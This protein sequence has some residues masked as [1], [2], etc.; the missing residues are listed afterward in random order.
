MTTALNDQYPDAIVPALTGENK[1]R[2]TYQL[3]IETV[4]VKDEF[5]LLYQRDFPLA[6]RLWM[7]ERMNARLLGTSSTLTGNPGRL[8]HVWYVEWGFSL[9][10]MH[11][12]LYEE[13]Q[14][15]D[16]PKEMFGRLNN[17]SYDVLVPTPYDPGRC[18]RVPGSTQRCSCQDAPISAPS[19]SC[20]ESISSPIQTNGPQRCVARL[21]DVIDVKPGRLSDLADKK[22]RCFVENAKQLFGITLVASGMRVAEPRRLVQVWNLPEAD[23]L[24]KAALKF[25]DAGWYQ[26][27]LS[28][29][30]ASEQQELLL[31]WIHDP[32]PTFKDNCWQFD[33]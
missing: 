20:V 6:W 10:E 26:D 16:W 11:A 19:A 14:R 25:E 32:R 22:K 13:A 4:D 17:V 18:W 9:A 27:M 24:Q 5:A 29:D 3:M 30:V 28:N 12:A 21:L 1:V 31:P 33:V 8:I 23:S 7:H 15:Q 2:R